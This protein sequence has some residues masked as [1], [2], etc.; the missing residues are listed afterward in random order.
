MEIRRK[1]SPVLFWAAVAA[2]C[3]LEM[4]FLIAIWD[5][6]AVCFH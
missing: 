2:I 6:A 1:E 4:C 5:R 3:V